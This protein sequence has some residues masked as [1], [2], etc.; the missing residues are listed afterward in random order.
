[1]TV[2]DGKVVPLRRVEST[3][4]QMS[5]RALVSALAAGDRAALGALYDRYRQ[6]VY[7]FVARMVRGAELEDLVQ[8]VFLEAHRSAPRFRGESSVK[9]WLFGIANNLVRG[10]IRGEQRRRSA[11]TRLENAPPPSA[12]S[13]AE[14]ITDEQRRRWVAA[15]VDTLTPA[16]K[17]VYV[18][19]VLE[20][21][22]GKEAGQVLGVRE[23]S[24]YRRLTDA[25]DALR[26]AI[27]EMQR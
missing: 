15:A 10:H 16:L 11:T 2:G 1:M 4:A 24:I 5:D 20:E 22:S 17:E 14:E 9:T 27:E 26:R 12:R 3:P 7:R 13:V 23:A 21:L 18:L 6:D 19:C 25:R 8:S